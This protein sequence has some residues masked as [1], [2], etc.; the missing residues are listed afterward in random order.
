[1]KK[2]KKLCNK[3]TKVILITAPV[4][5]ALYSYLKSNGINIIHDDFIDFP[6]LQGIIKYNQKLSKILNDIV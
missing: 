5:K 6:L 3:E 4:F 2:I 1:L